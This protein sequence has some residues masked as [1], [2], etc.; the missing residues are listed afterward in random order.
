L[1]SVKLQNIWKSFGKTQ[2]LK[3]INLEV[4][5]GEFMVLLG[6]SG[7]GKTT[8]LRTVAGLEE[9]DAGHVWIG[10]KL[11]D[12]LAPRE[13][14]IAMVFQN[15]ALYPH[16]TVRE[17]IEMPLRAQ[18][19]SKDVMA[20]SV[21]DV[22]KRLEISDLLDRYPRQLSGGQQQRVALARALVRRPSA[23]LLD[24]PLSNLDAKL[25]VSARTFLK[26]LQ[27]EMKITTIYVTHDQAEAMAMADRI[28]LISEGAIQQVGEPERVYFYP[29][30]VF[31]AGFLGSPSINFFDAR[32]EG[33]RLTFLGREFS[34]KDELDVSGEVTVGI[35]PEDVSL[36]SSNDGLQAK[37][38]VVEPL[39]HEF[40]LT[41]KIGSWVFKSRIFGR[42]SPAPGENVKVTWDQQAIMVFHQGKRVWPRL[43]VK[44]LRAG[45]TFH[46][47]KPK[48]LDYVALQH[49]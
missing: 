34:L 2:V 18:K 27:K 22:A 49:R 4:N 39:G 36:S 43:E 11:V 17:N 20:E 21:A 45:S 25:R 37:V 48:P 47:A 14:N 19:I 6:P 5:D 29:D 31:V 1:P 23:F 42:E 33:H 16:K 28:A 13:R 7:S 38:L 32:L 44:H 30:N 12:D 9:Q 40:I 8:A 35:R 10:D 41:L 24:E 15:Y 26:S 3:G 46:G